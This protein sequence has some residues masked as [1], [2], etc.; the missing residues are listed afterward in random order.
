MSILKNSIHK[1][2][3]VTQI[4]NMIFEGQWNSFEWW[5]FR[6]AQSVKIMLAIAIIVTHGLQ[7]YVAIDI[8]WNGYL[9]PLI[10]KQSYKIFLEYLVRTILVVGT[11]KNNTCLLWCLKVKSFGWSKIEVWFYH[12][13]T[14]C[15]LQVGVCICIWQLFDLCV[16]IIL[17]LP[18]GAFSLSLSDCISITTK[19]IW[20]H[21]WSFWMKL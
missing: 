20:I 17:I 5:C 7:C 15:I 12:N 21:T 1:M 19:D 18:V 11:G 8:T 10:E 13:V 4:I 3:N 9:E 14:I 6:L 2:E 16:T